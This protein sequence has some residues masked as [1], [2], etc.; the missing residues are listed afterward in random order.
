MER[1]EFGVEVSTAPKPGFLRRKSTALVIGGV[2]LQMVL[3]GG[4]YA[5]GVVR[6]RKAEAVD[7][8]Y[9]ARLAEKAAASAAEQAEAKKAANG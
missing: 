5:V 1:N 6:G 2:V 8:K 9:E 3:I 7:H 4:T